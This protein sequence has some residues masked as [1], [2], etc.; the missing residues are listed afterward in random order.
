MGSGRRCLTPANPLAVEKKEK[1]TV[2][3]V[4]RLTGISIS[5]VRNKLRV[6]SIL[7]DKTTRNY[8][9]LF[10]HLI[11]SSEISKILSTKVMLKPKLHLLS[12]RQSTNILKVGQTKLWD[13]ITEGRLK[14]Y[15][16]KYGAIRLLLEDVEKLRQELHSVPGEQN[17][18]DKV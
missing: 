17:G 3:E 4:A 1:Y 13:Y 6:G 5:T 7:S 12:L 16:N 2:W 10:I 8:K 11:P 14:K 15:F 9:G 18:A